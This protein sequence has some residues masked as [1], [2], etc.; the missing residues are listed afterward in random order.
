MYG[1]QR[2]AALRREVK[3]ALSRVLENRHKVQPDPIKPEKVSLPE[4]A[5][6]YRQCMPWDSFDESDSETLFSYGFIER[7]REEAARLGII[8]EY[9]LID[10]VPPEFREKVLAEMRR[11]KRAYEEALMSRRPGQAGPP[12]VEDYMDAESSY[13]VHLVPL[14]LP[15]RFL[16]H[17]RAAFA[18]DGHLR[19]DR[20]SFRSFISALE[21]GVIINPAITEPAKSFMYLKKYEEDAGDMGGS[22]YGTG[23]VQ[24]RFHIDVPRLM[25]SRSIF[26]D[27]ECMGVRCEYGKTFMVRGGIPVNAI[28]DWSVWDGEE[29]PPKPA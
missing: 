13:L 21:G 7:R 8:Y 10:A 9:R 1:R 12:S 14:S 26:A 29:P 28:Y 19:P 6:P 15:D 17:D 25:E 3:T 23:E 4:F 16:N 20:S 24:V 2:E 18:F 27:P 5:Y 22:V 11:W